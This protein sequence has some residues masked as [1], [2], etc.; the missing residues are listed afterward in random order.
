MQAGRAE[1]VRA[2]I[3][4]WVMGHTEGACAERFRFE[5]GIARAVSTGR[6]TVQALYVALPVRSDLSTT[7]EEL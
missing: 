7:V 2:D 6:W 5:S 4:A 3:A 1:H